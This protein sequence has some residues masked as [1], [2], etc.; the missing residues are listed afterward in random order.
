MYALGDKYGIQG[1]SKL[2]STKFNQSCGSAKSKDLLQSIPKIYDLTTESESVLRKYVVEH[3]RRKMGQSS[4]KNE[5]KTAYKAAI[6]VTPEF[7]TDLLH[8]CI[9]NPSTCNECGSYY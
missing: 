8:S 5:R 3:A 4:V 2:A 7:G 9:D 1:L 6:L